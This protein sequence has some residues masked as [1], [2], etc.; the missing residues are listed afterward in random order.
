MKNRIRTLSAEVLT[1]V[2]AV[3]LLIGGALG[4]V[5]TKPVRAGAESATT[6]LLTSEEDYRTYAAALNGGSKTVEIGGTS[7][8]IAGSQVM[9]SG[10][11]VLTGD[12]VSL[13]T[14]E[15]PF[16]GT[17]NGASH[18]VTVPEGTD[19][20]FGT[21]EDA[22]V[23]G[24]KVSGTAGLI[25][26]VAGDVTIL[27]GT[28][29]VSGTLIGTVAA[30]ATVTIND[31]A[32][33]ISASA[34]A[35]TNNGTIVIRNFS[36]ITVSGGISSDYFAVE[37]PNGVDYTVSESGVHTYSQVSGV[38]KIGTTYYTTV[39]A[40]IEAAS[41]ETTVILV[42]DVSEDIAVA[43]GQNIVLDLNGHTLA[44]AG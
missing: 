10:N 41:G 20:I 32:A 4:F 21:V 43:A 29:S 8:T 23:G 34:F 27:N 37:A 40:A 39:Q 12:P 22:T 19:Y 35:E 33:V 2:L 3:L 28:I 5:S 38:A 30:G 11:I 15:H 17:F 44:N 25:G 13:G 36:S 14:A 6:I 9:L 42:N 1:A 26:T 7:Y 16:K 24:I 18:T 31:N